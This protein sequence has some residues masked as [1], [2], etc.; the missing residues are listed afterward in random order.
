LF[1]EEKRESALLPTQEAFLPISLEI[2]RERTRD[3]AE[4]EN[5]AT[6]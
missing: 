2:A 3:A 4:E 1:E 5:H 6:E